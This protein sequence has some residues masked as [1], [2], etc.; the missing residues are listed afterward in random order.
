MRISIRNLRKV[1]ASGTVAL[2]DIDLD[3]ADGEFVSIVGPSGC[4][5]TT[6]LRIAAGLETATS[7]DVV[8]DAREDRAGALPIATVFQEYSLLPWMTVRQNVAFAFDR[9]RVPADEKRARVDRQLALV[10]LSRFADA[11]PHQ[12]SGGMKQRGA[13]ARAFAVDPQVLFMDEPF[14]ALDEQTRVGL[15][16]ELLTLWERD[17]KTVLFIT[18]SIEEAV[19]LSDRVVV[20]TAHPGKVREILAIPFARPRDPVELRADPEFGRISV[21]IWHLLRPEKATA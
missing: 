7:G 11:F 20:M 4:G 6:L 16:A 19:A 17:R 8:V 2:E 10:G 9:L 1:F 18:H 5:K 21:Q 15:A 3:V 14:G 12:F 13:V